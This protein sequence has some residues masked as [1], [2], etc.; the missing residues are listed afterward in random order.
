M[1]L[2]GA[3]AVLDGLVGAAGD[4]QDGVVLA[5]FAA[6][7]HAVNTDLAVILQRQ[8]VSPNPPP[9]P[10]Q[11][12]SAPVWGGGCVGPITGYFLVALTSH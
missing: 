8:P 12:P 1:Y 10:S 11:L 7:L 3:L 6:A 9:C 2:W 4:A 5:A